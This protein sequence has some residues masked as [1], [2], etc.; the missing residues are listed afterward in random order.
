MKR[1]TLSLPAVL[2]ISVLLALLAAVFAARMPSVLCPD[3]TM[4]YTLG[5]WMY[6]NGTLPVGNEPELV[7]NVWGY[8]YAFTPYLPT[9]LSTLFM[10][11]APA[12]ANLLLAARLANVA[13]YALLFVY[14]YLLGRELFSGIAAWWFAIV[15]TALPQAFFCATYINNDVVSMLSCFMIA[16]CL[17]SGKRKGWTAG[18]CVH[19]GISLAVCALSYYF[20]YG[21]ILAAVI[22]CMADGIKSLSPARLRRAV[23]FVF[24]T[25]FV[26]AGWYFIRNAILYHGDVF[27][28]AT[29]HAQAEIRAAAGY[30]VHF[31]IPAELTPDMVS[32]WF[33]NTF[34]SF[35]AVFGP[36]N[37][38]ATDKYYTC[39]LLWM[40]AGVLPG[41]V[42]Y[43]KKGERAK[44]IALLMLILLPLALS[45]HRSFTY[46]DQFQ[47]RYL[48]SAWPALLILTTN[49]Y[50]WLGKQIGRLFAEKIRPVVE[51]L[52]IALAS[53]CFV[54]IS[55]LAVARYLLPLATGL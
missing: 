7:A 30:D 43:A 49:G 37:V 52:P 17:V 51:L 5:N 47:G 35:F 55:V 29:Q 3:E 54:Y 45:M 39:F 15:A 53:A 41:L 31:G 32:F 2:H 18:V 42:H 24:L 34:R 6:R 25:A 23:L 12:G 46:D 27:G 11:L 16:Y 1:D 20:A 44:G 50:L 40:L 22:W 9:M 33:K 10:R 19:L 38:F 48:F 21:W 8:S 36:M 13:A 14:A 4:R 26:L 28:I